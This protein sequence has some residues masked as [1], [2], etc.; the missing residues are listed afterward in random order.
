MDACG[1]LDS[2]SSLTAELQTI[3]KTLPKMQSGQ[4]PRFNTQGD[5]CPL[6]YVH[7][8]THNTLTMQTQP[9]LQSTLLTAHQVEGSIYR[10]REMGGEY[11]STLS[12]QLTGLCG[13]PLD[14]PDLSNSSCLCTDSLGSVEKEVGF[15]CISFYSEMHSLGLGG[16]H[17]QCMN[18]G[19]FCSVW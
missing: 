16:H 2:Q 9:K 4:L 17:S 12:T 13:H 19:R 18:L 7:T 3:Q 6:I 11:L 15:W 8:S 14:Q 10:H 1:F 5:L